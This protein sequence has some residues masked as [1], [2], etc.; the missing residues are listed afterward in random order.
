[1]SKETQQPKNKKNTVQK[2]REKTRNVFSIISSSVFFA[3]F[4]GIA[5]WFSFGPR[6]E[7]SEIENRTL[8]SLPEFSWE[9]YFS[10]DFTSDVAEYFDDTVP[11]RDEMKNISNNLKSLFGLDLDDSVEII[12]NPVAVVDNS[13]ITEE[14]SE[15][16]SEDEAETESFEQESDASEDTSDDKSEEEESSEVETEEFYYDNGIVVVKQNGHYR[17]LELFGGGTGKSYINALNTIQEELG[18]SVTVYSM[19]IPMACEYYLPS[20]YSQYAASQKDCFDNIASQL[21]DGIISVD[22]DAILSQHTDEEIYC[23]TDHHWQPLG[24]YYA[25]QAF[26]EAADVE[27]ADL[28]TYEKYENE[29][30][31]GTMYAFSGSS[32]ILNDPETFTYYVPSNID[33]CTTYYYTTDFT[34][35]GTGNFF[36]KVNTANSYLVFMGGDELV[37]KVKTNVT[38]GRKLCIIKDSY[39]N[40]EVAYYMGSFE[41]IYVIDMR[42]FELNL[43]D[44]VEEMGI[45]DLLFTM[46]SYSVVGENADNLDTLI[47][48]HKGETIVDQA[49]KKEEEYSD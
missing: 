29:G 4:F 27:F 34:Y 38:N 14:A 36:N 31:V 49:V 28:S 2:K 26:A 1:M 43:V 32:D 40:A 19:P 37:V 3:V 41:E 9:S 45:T 21:S 47:T 20:E 35:T 7:I 25:A 46:C 48:Q 8:A 6:S 13:N 44:F 5:L 15:E 30:F 11:Y 22:A 12:G 10:G 42:Y 23:R 18:D 16:T 17:A 24:A 33:E 39:G